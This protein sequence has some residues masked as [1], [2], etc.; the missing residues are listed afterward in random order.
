MREVEYDEDTCYAHP[1]NFLYFCIF[2]CLNFCISVKEEPV[3][4]VEYD[5]DGCYAP[6]QYMAAVNSGDVFQDYSFF[7][8]NTLFPPCPYM[9]QASSCSYSEFSASAATPSPYSSS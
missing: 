8:G 2:V 4:E 3:R 9:V 6:D 7:I 1:I 5:E